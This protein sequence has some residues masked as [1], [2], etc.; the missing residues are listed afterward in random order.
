MCI[1][2]CAEEARQ[3]KLEEQK[4]EAKKINQQQA[5][6]EW[7]KKQLYFA[8]KRRQEKEQKKELELET[9]RK[10]QQ[11]FFET[12]TPYC[13]S[14]ENVFNKNKENFQFDTIRSLSRDYGIFNEL[15]RGVYQLETHELLGQYIFSYGKMHQGKL[16]QAIQSI[17]KNNHLHLNGQEIEILDYGCGQGLGTI[18]FLD[19]IKFH[20]NRNC[21]IFKIKLIE[22]SELALKRAALNVRYVLRGFLDQPQNVYAIHKELDCISQSDLA[23]Q[24]NSIKIHIFSNII[25]IECFNILNIT[26]KI[27]K[28]Q[29]GLNFFICTSPNIIQY[30]NKRMDLFQAELAN[31][32]I[33]E[34]ISYR[35]DSIPNP[36]PNGKSW[37]RYERIFKIN[38]N[39][40]A[41]I[42]INQ[43]KTPRMSIEAIFKACNAQQAANTETLTNQEKPIKQRMPIG[44]LFKIQNTQQAANTIMPNGSR[45]FPPPEE[46]KLTH[47]NDS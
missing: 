9:E 19:Y 20:T 37:T 16:K 42:P 28:T 2:K 46:A 40:Q 1:T 33:M 41:I 11:S 31:T 17:F 15:N 32:G 39:Q 21:K 18:C 7:R 3:A 4:E 25:D 45:N 36:N 13:A 14:I 29:K 12:E 27:N 6:N 30:R 44:E 47:K 38:I 26:D 23:T 8:N 43:N 34:E 10:I 24:E 35:Q 22:P 5:E